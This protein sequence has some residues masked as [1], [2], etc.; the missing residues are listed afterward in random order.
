MYVVGAALMNRMG[1]IWGT[2]LRCLTDTSISVMHT[3]CQELSAPALQRVIARSHLVTKNQ[4]PHQSTRLSSCSGGHR[5]RQCENVW[6]RRHSRHG[7]S[8]QESR[9]RRRRHVP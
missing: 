6:G 1:S 2:S 7:V 4:Y 9:E 8:Y 5:A 3:L